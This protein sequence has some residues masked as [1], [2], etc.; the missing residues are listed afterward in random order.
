MMLY[1]DF[2]DLTSV[3]AELSTEEKADECVAHALKLRTAWSL[4]N[5]KRFFQ[6]GHLTLRPS[7]DLAALPKNILKKMGP[8]LDNFNHLEGEPS[9]GDSRKI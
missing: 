5:Y 6:V 4:Q 3:L 1:V 7:N 8:L 2:L 9:C